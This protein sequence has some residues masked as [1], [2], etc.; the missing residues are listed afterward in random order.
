MY[1]RKIPKPRGDHNRLLSNRASHRSLSRS[2]KSVRFNDAHRSCA[3]A[4]DPREL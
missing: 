4:H 3:S 2:R 1:N